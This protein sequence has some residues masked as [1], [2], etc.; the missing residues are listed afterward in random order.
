MPSAHPSL[1]VCPGWKDHGKPQ[2]ERLRDALEP[3]GW[4][5]RRAGI[6]DADWAP[7]ARKSV[8]RQ[9]S[10][11]QLA[12]DYDALADSPGAD[13]GAIGV[14]GFSYG[15]YEAALLTASRSPA[16][17]ALRSP[18]LYPDEDWTVP[19]EALDSDA[20]ERYRHLRITPGENRALA[21]CAAYRGDVL[22]IESECDE[23]IPR[24]VIQNYADAFGRARSFT[25]R[26]L[27]GADHQLTRPA[28]RAAY[29][30]LAVAWLGER[31]SAH[32]SG[33]P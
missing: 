24:E 21:C 7:R 29:H 4:H 11:Q 25:R 27:A 8:S 22:L 16:W 28:Y 5:C 2:Y 1:L 33:A 9:D 10:L 17:L 18:A 32:R 12:R 14:L 13:S 23:V 15:A 31:W 6:P 30:A 26:V 19:K 20:L 3:Q